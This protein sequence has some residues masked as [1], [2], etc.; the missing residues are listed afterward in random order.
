MN[1]RDFAA[2]MVT[3]MTELVHGSPDVTRGTFMLNR[4]DRGLLHSL[5]KLSAAGASRSTNG[6]ASIAAHVDHLRYGL[7]LLNRWAAGEYR[8]WKDADWTQS[9]RVTTV[10]E[11]VWAKLLADLR[12]EADAWL[13]ALGTPRD[14]ADAELTWMLGSIPHLAYHVGAI[15]QIDRDT[16]GPTAEDERPYQT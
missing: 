1:T 4:G 2:P 15:R 3:L 16:R 5:E 7:S 14:V 10:D 12:R 8:P 9:W 6:G 13:A 11:A